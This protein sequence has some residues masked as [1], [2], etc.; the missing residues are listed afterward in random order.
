MKLKV[1]MRV[2]VKE[3]CMNGNFKKGEKFTLEQGALEGTFHV[4]P[5]GGLDSKDIK[6]YFIRLKKKKPVEEPKKEEI[7]VLT[8]KRVLYPWMQKE[9]SKAFKFMLAHLSDKR[10]Y[11]KIISGDENINKFIKQI[12]DKALKFFP[13]LYSTVAKHYKEHGRELTE[14]EFHNL[15]V[16]R[17]TCMIVYEKENKKVVTLPEHPANCPSKFQDVKDLCLKLIEKKS[18]YNA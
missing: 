14:K 6:K 16:M 3:D 7:P 13:N 8:K 11:D 5:A 1:G 15:C 9:Q 4:G 18:I 17:L 10:G 2:K 12:V